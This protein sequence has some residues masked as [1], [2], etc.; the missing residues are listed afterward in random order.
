MSQYRVTRAQMRQ[1]SRGV[2]RAGRA[3]QRLKSSHTDLPLSIVPHTVCDLQ[4]T[5]RPAEPQPRPR[6]MGR[7][8]V[9][10]PSGSP[11][12][13]W[14]ARVKAEA[15]LAMGPRP[16]TLEPVEVLMV[17]GLVEA[18]GDLDNYIIG[19]LNAL[20]GIVYQDDRQVRKLAAEII[21]VNLE[22]CTIITVRVPGTR[23]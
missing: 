15:R 17:F 19:T 8:V 16:P 22:P 10:V 20:T 2:R 4:I 5:G 1:L 14:K 21:P 3:V 23:P 11:I 6:L 7:R 18:R 13:L 12:A 9:S